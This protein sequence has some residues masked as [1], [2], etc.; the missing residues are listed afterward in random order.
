MRGSRGKD[1]LGNLRRQK[2]EAVHN[3]SAGFDDGSPFA[4]GI[5]PV[6][7]FFLTPAPLFPPFCIMKTSALGLVSVAAV[8]V[9]VRVD[10][11][12]IR[13]P[14]AVLARRGGSAVT[15][16]HSFAAT[17]ADNSDPDD[18]SLR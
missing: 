17:T 6:P 2:R 3:T 7:S 16:V 15:H 13:R 1:I 14:S 4:Q 5:P 12:Q 10:F 11:K 18:V 9:A 8:V